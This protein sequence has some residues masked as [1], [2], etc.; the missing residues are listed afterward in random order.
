MHYGDIHFEGNRIE[1]ATDLLLLM[2]NGGIHFDGI[3]LLS[4]TGVESDDIVRTVLLFDIHNPSGLQYNELF[5]SSGC[6]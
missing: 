5:I 4:T 1:E 3:T 6:V 2:S